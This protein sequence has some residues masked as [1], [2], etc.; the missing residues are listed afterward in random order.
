MIDSCITN[1]L[2]P[3]LC[4]C[5]N[6]KQQHHD[7]Y[8]EHQKYNPTMRTNG[9]AQSSISALRL[10]SIF[11]FASCPI[12]AWSFG[13]PKLSSAHMTVPSDNPMTCT[14]RSVSGCNK[15]QLSATRTLLFSGKGFDNTSQKDATTN[16]NLK[17]IYSVPSLYDLAMGY[18]NYESEVEFLLDAHR[19]VSGQ[20]PKSVIEIASGPGRHCME[21]IKLN[22]VDRAI[23]LDL[24]QEMVD[25][26]MGVAKE[27]LSNKLS[28]FIFLCDDMRTFSIDEPC[29]TA[30]ILAG[31]LQHMTSNDDVIA[32]LSAT[33]RALNP[34]GTLILE[35]PHPTELFNMIDSTTNSWDVPLQDDGG[36]QYGEL[37]VVW[38]DENDDI[39]PIRQ[40]R[41]NT[42]VLKLK[43]VED[44]EKQGVRGVV[45]LKLFTAQ[46]IELF[47]RCTG[48]EVA[49]M[50]GALSGK[51]A[52][53]GVRLV[54]LRR[55]LLLTSLIFL[56]LQ[57]EVD[58]N[59]EDT[60]YRLVCILRKT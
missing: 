15:N 60:A 39:D 2:G 35:L 36:N 12:A 28:K 46:E 49:G 31:S 42:V 22:L 59:N 13:Q 51:R 19:Q 8:L 38:G 54:L 34:Q 5:N 25:Y 30:W 4:A 27:E 43:G 9:N 16:D 50:Y 37:H 32:C 10:L 6:E 21:A 45:P 14:Q 24:S 57:D 47:A 3:L 26:G 20:R 33:H 29:D 41:Q 55:F 56:Q 1:F 7:N 23:A 18:R 44:S 48:Y 17:K 11:L 40:I 52:Q 53:E 58:I